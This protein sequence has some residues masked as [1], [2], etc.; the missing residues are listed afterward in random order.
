MLLS[1]KRGTRCRKIS[2]SA[3]AEP[4]ATS[5]CKNAVT[6]EEDR[7]CDYCHEK[8]AEDLIAML[9]P[10]ENKLSLGRGTSAYSSTPVITL[11]VGF[12][13]SRLIRFFG[14]CG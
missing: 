2:A 10:P 5:R 7:M 8:A 9:P 1:P 4:T 11:G 13:H 6:H 3:K 12:G 14:E